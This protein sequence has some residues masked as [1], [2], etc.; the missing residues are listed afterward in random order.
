MAKQ[1]KR[2]VFTKTRFMTGRTYVTDPLT[3]AEAIKYYS[4]TLECGD[5]YYYE[6]GAKKVNRNPKTVKSLLTSLN[7]AAHNTNG[8]NE[9]YSYVEAT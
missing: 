6:K 4:Y 3:L 2:Y 9:F 7:N 1:E 5:S 8:G